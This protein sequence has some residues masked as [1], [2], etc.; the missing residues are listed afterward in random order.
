MGFVCRK[1]KNKVFGDIGYLGV[2]TDVLSNCDIRIL[3][4]PNCVWKILFIA[5]LQE[6][7]ND[8][9]EILHLPK[10]VFKSFFYCKLTQNLGG[11][12]SLLVRKICNDFTVGVIFQLGCSSACNQNPLKYFKILMSIETINLFTTIIIHSFI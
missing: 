3:L 4:Y 5:H 10:L 6:P 2:F 7:L 9:M 1:S 11:R 12:W 8:Q